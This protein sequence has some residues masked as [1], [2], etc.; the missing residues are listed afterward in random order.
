MDPCCLH[1]MFGLTLYTYFVLSHRSLPPSL[2]FF[3]GCLVKCIYS[4]S[5]LSITAFVDEYNQYGHDQGE[6]FEKM[7]SIDQGR[8]IKKILKEGRK[9][10]TKTWTKNITKLTLRIAGRKLLGEDGFKDAEETFQ[11]TG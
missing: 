11:L 10:N 4:F 8:S 3:H 7:N 2:S 9:K 5:D 6:A 1:L